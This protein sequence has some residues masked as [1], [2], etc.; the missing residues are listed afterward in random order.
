MSSGSMRIVLMIP[1]FYA[2]TFPV[3]R[4]INTKN[5][6]VTAGWF[7]LNVCVKKMSKSQTADYGGG[8]KKKMN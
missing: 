2:D 1:E 6:P 3:L 7:K 4:L 5:S 8:Y